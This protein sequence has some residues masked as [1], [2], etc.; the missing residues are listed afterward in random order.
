MGAVLLVEH[1]S[2]LECQSDD[3]NFRKKTTLIA[4]RS[5][6]DLVDIKKAVRGRN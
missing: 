2:D 5:S 4:W 3:A 1:I 6:L